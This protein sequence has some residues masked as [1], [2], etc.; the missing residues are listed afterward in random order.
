MGKEYVRDR[1]NRKVTRNEKGQHHSS[2][3]KPA[4]IYSSG[5]KYWCKNGI[6]HRDNDRPAVIYSNGRKEWWVNGELQPNKDYI[7]L[8]IKDNKRYKQFFATE[9][10]AK[11]HEAN[12]LTKGY[13]SWVIENE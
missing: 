10:E 2:N 11:Q 3:D 1:L 12:M 7:C 13:C 9:S 8:Y 4:I 6:L 5:S